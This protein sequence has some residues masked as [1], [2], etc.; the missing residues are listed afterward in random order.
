MHVLFLSSVFPRFGHSEAVETV[1]AVLLKAAVEAGH[2]VSWAT[3]APG[4]RFDEKTRDRL[5]GLGISYA[6]DFSGSVSWGQHKRGLIKKIHTLR[7]AFSRRYESELP[8]FLN[9][10]VTA[11]QLERT[12]ADAILLHW[13][14]YFEYLLPWIRNTPVYAYWARP[15]FASALST[16][17]NEPFEGRL[18]KRIR[19]WLTRRILQIQATRHFTRAGYLAGIANIC[20]LDAKSYV[21]AG[22]ACRYIPNTWPDAFGDQCLLKRK[23]FE[24]R[25]GAFDI[26]GGLGMLNAT[27]NY[28]GLSYLA[29]KIL[30]ILK[31]ELLD[32]NWRVNICGKGFEKLHKRLQQRLGTGHVHYKGFVDDIDGEFL[33]NS[34]FLMCNNAGPYTGGYTRVVYAMSAGA[35]L[36]GHKKLSDSM[37]EIVNGKNALLGESPSEIGGMVIAAFRNPEMRWKIAT[38]ARKTYQ[39]HFAPHQVFKQINAMIM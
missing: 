14:S 36:I 24:R 19:R 34:V 12:G 29:D 30:P 7:S 26:L 28:Y 25:S 33:S 5:Q 9:P 27:G 10:D 31:A 8:H 4:N 6:G 20:A 22:K 18:G 32:Q 35:C 15:R 37:P 16:I 17:E 1:L 21:A 13:D 38:A 11:G 23:E 2:R 39:E 3:V